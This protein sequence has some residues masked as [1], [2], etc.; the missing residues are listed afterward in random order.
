MARGNTHVWKI[1][2]EIRQR[3]KE[4][5]GKKRAVSMKRSKV[6]SKKQSQWP[7]PTKSKYNS[8]THNKVIFYNK[9]EKYNEIQLTIKNRFN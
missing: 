6:G 8:N 7:I 4:E 3:N 5:E 9:W 1:K 2:N